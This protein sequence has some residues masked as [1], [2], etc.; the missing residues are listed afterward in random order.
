ML[1]WI[2]NRDFY[3]ESRVPIPVVFGIF[4]YEFGKDMNQPLLFLDM[5]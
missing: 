1:Q 2:T 5:V 3:S 4:T